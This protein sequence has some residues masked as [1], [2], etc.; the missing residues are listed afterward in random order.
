MISSIHWDANCSIDLVYSISGSKK[1]NSKSDVLKHSSFETMIMWCM[2]VSE[3]SN[4]IW[5]YRTLKLSM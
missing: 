5:P 2:L 3:S 4:H 1:L